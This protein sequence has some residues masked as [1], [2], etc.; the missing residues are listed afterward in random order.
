M[1]CVIAKLN[2][3]TTEKLISIQRAA[4]SD[5]V[6]LKPLYGHITIATYAGDKEAQFVRFCKSLIGGISSFTVK[7]NKIEVLEESSIIVASPEKTGTLETL[8]QRIA[9]E[10]NGSLNRWTQADRWYPHTTL[11]YEPSQDLHRICCSM[12]ACF[13]PFSAQISRIEF[14]RVLESGYDVIDGVE[15]L[16]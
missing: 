5:A 6:V 16:N 3:E 2:A 4:L 1:L 13:M 14:S 10:Y 8:H 11:L 9:D 12:S 15:L 7:Y